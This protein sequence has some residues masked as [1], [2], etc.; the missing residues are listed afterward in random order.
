MFDR[1]RLKTTGQL[2]AYAGVMADRYAGVKALQ[3]YLQEY[4]QLCHN[5]K[6]ADADG[7]L[8]SPQV[9]CKA[10]TPKPGKCLVKKKAIL[11]MP[12]NFAGLESVRS[13]V[14]SSVAL[15]P[16][17]AT[18][19]LTGSPTAT[20][21][22]AD[23]VHPKRPHSPAALVDRKI[24]KTQANPKG[25]WKLELCPQCF[26]RRSG[27]TEIVYVEFPDG[28]AISDLHGGR[29]NS[30]CRMLNCPKYVSELTDS[31][32]VTWKSSLTRMR[33]NNTLTNMY[34]ELAK[35]HYE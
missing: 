34:N 18:A 17:D 11:P 3:P 8:S 30:I 27:A 21:S 2:S 1:L 32:K 33:R 6:Q 16:R 23:T 22:C 15:A 24:A 9:G 14:V 31:E 25:R 20:G 10:Q 13:V 4:K 5:L 29:Q 12:S 7:V 19:P 26:I 28:Q 35:E